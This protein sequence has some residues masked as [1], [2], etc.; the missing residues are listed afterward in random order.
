MFEAF[1]MEYLDDRLNLKV[2]DKDKIG[3][4]NYAI[5]AISKIKV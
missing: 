5:S 4:Q 1:L 2:S 3:R